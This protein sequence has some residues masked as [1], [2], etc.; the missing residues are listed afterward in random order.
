MRC[1]CVQATPEVSKHK[2]GRICHRRLL[3]GSQMEAMKFIATELLGF[4]TDY[5]VIDF[6]HVVAV[7]QATVVRYGTLKPRSFESFKEY[8]AS[9]LCWLAL[10]KQRKQYLRAILWVRRRVH[11]LGRCQV[12]LPYLVGWTG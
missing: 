1:V 10:L 11:Q 4:V 9:P 6:G 8:A 5:S 7:E 2:H 12:L 3:L